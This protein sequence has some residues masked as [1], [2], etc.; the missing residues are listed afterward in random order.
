MHRNILSDPARDRYHVKQIINR[1]DNGAVAVDAK[2]DAGRQNQK[3]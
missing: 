3:V 1:V 2:S